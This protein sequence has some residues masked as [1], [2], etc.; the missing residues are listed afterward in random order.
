MG[1][2]TRIP[3][4][5]PLVGKMEYSQLRLVLMHRVVD[6]SCVES[7]TRRTVFSFGN[8]ARN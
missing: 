7:R 4:S 6:G 2:A 3:L 1:K 8:I 5:I